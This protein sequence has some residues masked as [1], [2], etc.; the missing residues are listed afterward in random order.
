MRYFPG[1]LVD[2]RAPL[3]DVRFSAGEG[4]GD[5][6]RMRSPGAGVRGGDNS[7]EP[8]GR[9]EDGFKGGG[10]RSRSRGSRIDDS[11][12]MSTIF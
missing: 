2:L 4:M 12:S 10:L 7:G 8:G 5:D 6:G 3:T 9:G 11:T 1:E